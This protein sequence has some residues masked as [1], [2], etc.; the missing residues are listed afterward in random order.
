MRDLTTT[1]YAILGLLAIKPW[2]AYDLASQMQRSM[3]WIWPRAVSAIYA[4]PKNLVEHGLARAKVE[5]VGARTRTVYRVT[6][7]G[8][9]RLAEWLATPSSPPQFE[10]EAAV[11]LMF[12]DQGSQEALLATLAE[13]AVQARAV[14][15]QMVAIGRAYEHGDNPFPE[16]A[17]VNV[18][19]GRLVHDYADMLERWAEWATKHVGAWPSTGPGAAG[20][21]EGPLAE[22]LA[23]YDRT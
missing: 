16:R 21:A 8:R 20:L 5:H 7:K 9:R 2:S 11:K 19:A 22:T 13:L 12:A 23:L 14:Q 15:N 18:L 4:E 3:R 10:A 6:A 17:H 1:S